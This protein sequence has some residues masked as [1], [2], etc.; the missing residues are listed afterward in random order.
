MADYRK[1]DKVVDSRCGSVSAGETST[2][3]ARCRLTRPGRDHRCRLA[4]LR[5]P[6]LT[7][8][9]QIGFYVLRRSMRRATGSQRTG[10][11]P[12]LNSATTQLL[13]FRPIIQLRR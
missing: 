8:V 10:L 13:D 11:K 9:Q 2:R 4:Y 6:T 3:P 5:A 12:G 7:A 1:V